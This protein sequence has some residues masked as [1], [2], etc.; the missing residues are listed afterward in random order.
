MSTE[1]P[2]LKNMMLED[3]EYKFDETAWGTWRRFAYPDGNAF[4]EYVTHLR[5]FGLPLLHFTR[6]K[7]PETGR[8][9]VAKGIIAIG[10]MAIGLLAIG[11]ASA[12]IVAI[13][14]LAVGVLFGLGQAA[15]GIVC[16]GQ[17]AIGVVFALGQ[18]ACGYACVAQFGVGS[19]VLAQFGFGIHVSD[20]TQVDPA[21]MQFFRKCLNF[22]EP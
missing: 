22:L 6:G 5:F 20:M 21:V 19:Y 18:F 13:G 12:G 9:I 16:I 3:I 17:L 14:Q 2:V 10:R 7:C 1:S 11:Q 4:E 8:R 15:T